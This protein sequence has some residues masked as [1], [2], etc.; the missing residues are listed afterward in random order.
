MS[1]AGANEASGHRCLCFRRMS[2][3]LAFLILLTLTACGG[4][5][6]VPEEAREGEAEV[7]GEVA[8]AVAV[9]TVPSRLAARNTYAQTRRQNILPGL[10]S[11]GLS[12]T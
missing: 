1:I 3:L 8:E 7:E 12:T 9:V 2:G 11:I 6:Q 10:I 4:E 5:D